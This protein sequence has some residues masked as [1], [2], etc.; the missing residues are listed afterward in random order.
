MK[1]TLMILGL[2]G[3]MV[4]SPLMAETKINKTN[5][6]T[7]YDSVSSFCRD[8][9]SVLKNAY[10]QAEIEAQAGNPGV[11]A[12]I[13]EKGLVD[14]ANRISPRY[15]QTLTSKAIQRGITL[16]NELKVT[17][18]S[19]QK[20]RAINHFLFNYFLFIENVSNRLDIPYF[21]TGSAFSRVSASNAQFERLF[22]NFASEQVKMVLDTMST[23]DGRTIYPIGSPTLLLTALRVTTQAMAN[24]LSESIFAM[25][26]ACTIQALETASQDIAFYLN[27]RAS[28]ADEFVAVQELVGAVKRATAKGCASYGNDS[29]GE[30]QPKTTDALRSSITL[31]SGTTQQ[32]RL[33]SGRYIKKLIIS[34]EGIRNDAMFD[35][36]VNGDVKGTIYVPGRD[37]SYFVTVEDYA[38]SIELV[39]RGGNALVSRI[40][41][42]AE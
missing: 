38:D 37:P 31:Y 29:Y 28:Y 24:D 41:V 10:R 13:L 39:S 33:N 23:E 7:E 22:V 12:A 11:S 2:V 18:D 27:T 1:N 35:V 15:A 19:K 42:V 17:A 25:R 16:L 14:A 9:L 5:T 3:L 20:T 8:R 32:V 6:A 30:A 34:A 36:V 4:T 40:L 26:Y 21:Q